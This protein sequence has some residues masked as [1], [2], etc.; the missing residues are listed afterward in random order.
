MKKFRIN[1][2][3]VGLLALPLALMVAIKVAVALTAFTPADQ[4]TGYVAQDE[5]T[6]YNLKS[7]IEFLFRGQYEREYWSGSFLAYP[8]DKF[9]NVDTAAPAWDAA[10]AMELQN[11]DTDRRIATMRDDGVAVPFRLAS[12]SAAQ[13]AYF[14]GSSALVNYL[15]G[16]RDDEGS[17]FRSRAGKLGDI[18]H[19][20]P[21]YVY[22]ETNPTVFVGANDGMLHAFNAATP[23]V[24]SGIGGSERW[25]YVP[26]MLLPKMNKLAAD[27]YV[28]DYFV[29]GQINITSVD[30]G[31][32]RILVG[33]LGAGGKGLYALDISGSSGLVAASESDVTAKVLWEIAPTRLNYALPAATNAYVNLGYTYGTVTVARMNVSGT[34]TDVVIVGN[35]YN[36]GTGSYAGC[37]SGTPNYG[38]CGGNYAAYLYVIN[39]ITGQLVKS[40]KA[41]ASGTALSPNGLSTPSA[42][43]TNGDGL[44]DRVYAG[45]LNGT[46]WK[47]DLVAGTS[48]ALLVTSPAQAI[49]VTPAVAIHPEGG[50]MVTFATGKMLIASDT[51]DSSVHYAYGIWDGAPAANAVL[52]SQSLTERSYTRGGVTTRIRRVTS[53]Q[54]TWTSG[55]TNHKGWR[56]ALPAAEKVIGEGAFI[57]NGRYYFTSHN[58]TVVTPVPSTSTNIMGENW[59]MELDYLTGGT[60]N[61]PFLDLSGDI[62][63]DND[64]RIRYIATDPEVDSDP[65]KLDTPILS[66]DGISVG[67]FISTGVLSQPILVQLLSLNDTLFN[68]NPDVTIP[69][70]VLGQGVD[71]GHFDQDIYYGTGNAQNA[72]G[73]VKFTYANSGSARTVS[74]LKIVANG[75]T[76]YSGAPGSY[77]PK[78]LDDFLAG[79]S[80]T[81]YVVSTDRND[82]NSTI[83]IESKATGAVYNGPI[84][85]TITT[86]GKTPGYEKEDLSGGTTA[87]VGDT[88]DICRA[89]N[90]VHQYDDKYDVTG[91]NMLNASNSAQNLANAI[92]DQ[93]T[94]FKV[95][96]QN[97]YLSPAV[98]LHIGTPGYLFDVNDG[99]IR[100][101]DFVTSSTLDVTALPT[102]R[103]AATA[104]ATAQP[105]ESLTVNMPTD[106]LGARD[107]WGN[108]DV[109][110][111][112]HPTVY[113]CAYSSA[114][115]NDG[116]MYRPVVPPVNGIDGPGVNG[117]SSMTT[118]ASATGARHN[119]ALTIQLIA[120]NTPNSAIEQNVPGRPEYGWRV[121]SANFKDYVLAEYNTYW[122]HPNGIC[123]GD[124]GWSKTPGA[125]TGSSTAA[126]KAAGS[127]DPKIGELGVG[128]GAITDT[129]TTTVG[130]VTTTVITYS[131]GLTARIERTANRTNGALDGSVTIVTKDTT[132][133]STAGCAGVTQVIASAKGSIKT[134]GDERGLQAR[135]GRISWRELVAP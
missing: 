71:G 80:S 62:K 47:F 121:K 79:K 115:T 48:S 90:H 126:T 84:I 83:R 19:S 39:A 120:A 34:P 28:H 43:D 112:L 14:S 119:G 86:T 24:G 89:K 67:K 55:A 21:L 65:T 57:E 111:G 6:N 30:G 118:P 58:P 123:Y 29:D 66:T 131:S 51:T 72:V 70:V 98:Q 45:D 44:V 37:T 53:N 132:C 92:P 15:R 32:Q 94:E 100:I 13:Q 75:E 42:I 63:L 91:V 3:W 23:N 16:D 7:G 50:Y 49:T 104:S 1:P 108:G 105:I 10:E 77:K 74:Q 73:R 68:Q 82:S 103:R 64:D 46:M 9:G 59:L 116:N 31:A 8:A 5:M 95:L 33:G 35:G 17:P 54:P 133:M 27:P 4:P 97:Q 128:A 113:Y 78:D 81:N 130:D 122:H 41:G 87:T 125:D 20:R 107:W 25:A 52:L 109:R 124:S 88:C 134:G 117:W 85:V 22:D 2:L 127:S 110:V 56:V 106:A 69:K 11:F 18:I 36:D 93:A 129:T 114:G 26:S 38:N 60:K 101:K 61:L 135:T 76:I 102:Y 12:L 40:I 96:A 99:Y